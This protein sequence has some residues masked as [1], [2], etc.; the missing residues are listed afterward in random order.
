MP[1]EEYGASE[2]VNETE[3]KD[4]FKT[5]NVGDLVDE[6]SRGWVRFWFKRPEDQW[7]DNFKKYLE[8]PRKWG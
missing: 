2:D 8:S 1:E 5:G 4:Y 7:P 6:I 3:F